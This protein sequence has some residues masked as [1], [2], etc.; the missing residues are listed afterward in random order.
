MSR[1]SLLVALSV[2]LFAC[3]CAA[4]SPSAEPTTAV[5]LPPPASSIP[6]DTPLGT[7]ALPPSSSAPDAA[8]PDDAPPTPPPPVK[9]TF[10]LVTDG[11]RVTLVH[12]GDRRELPLFPITVAFDPAKTWTLHATK[13]GFCELVRPLD[14][15]HGPPVQRVDIELHPGCR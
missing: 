6:R 4:A 14:L 3:A 7:A 5:V 15:A 2:V 8:A 10:T 1:A 13:P 11:A 12:D 9:I